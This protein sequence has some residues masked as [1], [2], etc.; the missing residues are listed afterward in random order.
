MIKLP[1]AEGCR[2]T[3]LS[4]VL[5]GDDCDSDDDADGK[6][7]LVDNCPLVANADQKHEDLNYDQYGEDT[8]PQ[9]K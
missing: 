6:S 9:R 2:E 1:E 7:D 3:S 5:T 8:I 4:V